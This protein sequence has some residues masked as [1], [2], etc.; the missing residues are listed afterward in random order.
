MEPPYPWNLGVARY[1]AEDQYYKKFKPTLY[2]INKILKCF[3]GL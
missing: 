3:E 1:W 2:K